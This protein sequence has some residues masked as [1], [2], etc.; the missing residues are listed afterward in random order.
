MEIRTVRKQDSPAIR[1][2]ARRSL[3]A[4]YSLGPRAITGAIEEWYDEDR[5]TGILE[6]EDRLLLVA[7]LDGQVV[8]FS[9]SLITDEETAQL[10]WLHIDPFHRGGEYGIA[11]YEATRE[12]LE[13][14]GV[15]SLQ[16]RV[17]AD[18]QDGA[19]FYEER[20]LSKIG[21]ESVEIDGTTHTEFVYADVEETGVEEL[22]VDGETMYLNRDSVRI[23]SFGPFYSVYTDPECEELYGYWCSNC[24]A[25]PVP[26]D[27]MG[28]LKCDEC[29]NASKPTRWDAAYL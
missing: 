3:Q 21:E 1:D 5:L 18:N 6:D 2:V 23:G 4:S 24:E 12:R 27:T 14:R 11:L 19:A 28:R 16:G 13:Q 26:M 10:L 7:D 20:G 8:G 29:G 9:E 22:L 17:L 15:T 25:V